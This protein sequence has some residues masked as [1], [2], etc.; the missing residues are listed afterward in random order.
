[1]IISDRISS[2]TNRQL[3]YHRSKSFDQN[4]VSSSAIYDLV[5]EDESIGLDEGICNEQCS[6]LSAIKDDERYDVFKQGERSNGA[7]VANGNHEN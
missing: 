7:L 1:M 3:C 4:V 6:V 5:R 2:S